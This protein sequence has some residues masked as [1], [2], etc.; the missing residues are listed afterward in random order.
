MNCKKFFALMACLLLCSFIDVWAASDNDSLLVKVATEYADIRGLFKNIAGVD[1]AV[2]QSASYHDKLFQ[3]NSEVL[4]AEFDDALPV[5]Q[6][7]SMLKFYCEDNTKQTLAVEVLLMEKH[8]PGF[9]DALIKTKS[10]YRRLMSLPTT[11]YRH[12]AE[13]NN[14]ELKK[15]ERVDTT[16]LTALCLKKGTDLFNSVLLPFKSPNGNV[17]NRLTAKEDKLVIEIQTSDKSLMAMQ[18]NMD[19]IKRALYV[20][21]MI[22]SEYSKEMTKFVEYGFLLTSDT[23]KTIEVSYSSEE[24]E[25]LDS[26]TTDA[27]DRQMYVILING[28]SELPTK[29]G[30]YQ[31]RVGFE[32]ADK[33]LSMIDEVRTDN[34]KVKELM[35]H[36]EHIKAEYIGHIFSS[37][38]FYQNFSENGVNIKRVYRGLGNSDISYMM[39]AKEIENLL[40]SPQQVK[41][42]LLLQSKMDLLTLQ[43]SMQ[44]C[45]DGYLCPRQVAI[46]GGYVIYSIV[47]NIPLAK[48]KQYVQR[49]LS[50]KALEIYKSSSNGIL[51]DAVK[52]LHKGFIYRLYNSDMTL[53][54]DTV[55]PLDSKA[56]V[57]L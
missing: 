7:E 50:E 52:K 55:I 5:S 19:L 51:R 6:I 15:I 28:M 18:A 40:K 31:T 17:L 48:Y 56:L 2:Q 14:K 45:N 22:N 25:Q 26:L 21:P 35:R 30:P 1:V 11:D 16:A 46:E 10:S 39:T 8:F 29:V 43:Y 20:C 12:T 44:K 34:E 36:Q 9:L 49:D 3:V 23:G 37:E 27:T 54:H 57:T 47:A 24:R 42:S 4:R 41:D 53:H 38:K 13:L 33:T 32:Y